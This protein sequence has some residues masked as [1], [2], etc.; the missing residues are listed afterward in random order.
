[1][2]NIIDRQKV[3]L[4]N[5]QQCVDRLKEA[6]HNLHNIEDELNKLN[7]IIKNMDKYLDFHK[8]I[9]QRV[10]QKTFFNYF[11]SSSNQSKLIEWS[12]DAHTK[13]TQTIMALFE[14]NNF[15]NGGDNNDKKER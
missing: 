10:L 7:S 3:L 13:A 8:D 12:E 1:M 15:F 4:Q 6:K 5:K 9:F 14:K 11:K 2:K